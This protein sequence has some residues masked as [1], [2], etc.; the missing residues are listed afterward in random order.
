[1]QWSSLVCFLYLVGAMKPLLSLQTLFQTS[2]IIHVSFILE[3]F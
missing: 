1:L 3:H 2:M